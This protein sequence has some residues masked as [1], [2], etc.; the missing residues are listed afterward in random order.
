MKKTKFRERVRERVTGLKEV[1]SKY[2]VE[3]FVAGLTMF[4]GLLFRERIYKEITEIWIAGPYLF[5]LAYLLNSIFTRKK[6]RIVYYLGLVPFIG[7]F[8]VPL[9]NWLLSSGYW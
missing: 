9:D 8:F 4:A 5:L 6:T 1:V 2:P 3:T 7:L